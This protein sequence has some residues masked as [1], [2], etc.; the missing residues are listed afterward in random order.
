MKYRIKLEGRE[1]KIEN[2]LFYIFRKIDYFISIYQS[3]L[4][5]L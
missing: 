1:R 5:R 3:L 4:N 2:G